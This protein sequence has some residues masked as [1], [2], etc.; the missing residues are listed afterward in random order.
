MPVAPSAALAFGRVPGWACPGPI[1]AC[2]DPPAAPHPY[3]NS[4]RGCGGW[5]IPPKLPTVHANLLT[6]LM[7]KMSFVAGWD[8]Q[9]IGIAP[10]GFAMQGYGKWSQRD[11]GQNTPLFARAIVVGALAQPPACLMFC[12]LDLGYITHAMREGVCNELAA[13]MGDAFD[14]DRLVLTCTHTHSGPGGCSHDV[15]YNIVT[16]GF[17]PQ[18]LERIVRAAADAILNAWRSAA[19]TDLA[20]SDGPF[21]DDI[22]VAWNRSLAAY[23]R[24]P[25]VQHRA[26]NETHLALDRTMRVLGFSRGG[27]PG[28]MLSLFGVHATCIG[29]S[30]TLY[31]GDNKGYA[32]AHAE[33][34]LHQHGTSSPKP[35][36]PVAI[37]AQ[38]TAGDVSPHYHGPG[39]TARRRKITGDAE[40]AYAKQNGQSQ[41]EQALGLLQANTGTMINGPIDAILCYV[42]FTTLTADPAYAGGETNAI[43]SEPCHG[44]AFFAG[45]PV[46][47]PGLPKPF[48][49]LVQ[50]IAGRI[51][52]HRLKNLD[53][54]SAADQAYYRRI[55]AAQ[56]PKDIMQEAGRKI[57][58]GQTLDRISTPDFIDPAVAEIKRQ[59]RSGAMRNSAMVPTVLP[60]QILIIGQLALVCAPGEFT[61]MAGER[62]RQTVGERL[63]ARGIAHVLLCTYC[64]EYM[65]YVTTFEE[66]QEQA[67][68]GGHT[69]FG[70]WTLAAFQTQFAALADELCKPSAER[71][72]DR[73]TRPAPTPAADLALR[74]AMPERSRARA[75]KN[76]TEAQ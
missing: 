13:A 4:G 26:E 10:L 16:P 71:R 24:N 76:E 45:T 51:K 53:S 6:D 31:D 7:H 9:D 62:L 17:V 27:R 41:A 48:L 50:K 46:D 55:Y 18:Y 43:T 60:L 57:M 74:T 2:V 5:D 22:A 63:R 64:N 30:N 66:Y 42:D 14:P 29:S 25:D 75:T 11:S 44:A 35:L 61:T 23:N 65:G 21:T 32:A 67:Y 28:A 20:L 56:G 54:Y 40:Y 72:H 39:Q 33:A 69:I 58:L 19:A 34:A 70:Q 8:R 12:C 38:S 47:G 15:M 73:V 59:A 68:E 1:G 52:R 49:W 36:P 3:P 37:F